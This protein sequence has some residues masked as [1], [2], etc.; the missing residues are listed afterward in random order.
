[1][2]GTAFSPES[3]LENELILHYPTPT[4]YC[5]LTVILL[6]D[7]SC[8]SNLKDKCDYFEIFLSTNRNLTD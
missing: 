2:P 3:T 5:A 7:S 1:M 4:C 8:L 6:K